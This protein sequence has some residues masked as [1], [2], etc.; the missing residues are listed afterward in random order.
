MTPFLEWA[1]VRSAQALSGLSVAL[2]LLYGGTRPTL[3]ERCSKGTFG[4]IGQ[5]KNVV[6][7][8]T[9]RPGCVIPE[10]EPIERRLTELWNY[11]RLRSPHKVAG[12][13]YVFSRDDGLQNHDVVYTAL[14][15]DGK[16]RVPLDPNTDDDQ[17]DSAGHLAL[18]ADARVRTTPR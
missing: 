12:R 16:A 3:L 10:R 8:A 7:G 6:S 9:V 2:H 18:V 13:C 1:A 17:I 15:P 4:A 5:A 14:T 11:E